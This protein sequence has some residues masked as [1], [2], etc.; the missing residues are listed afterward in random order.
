MWGGFLDEEEP[1]ASTSAAAS[2]G[3]PALGAG[4]GLTWRGDRHR[5]RDRDYPHGSAGG[6]AGGARFRANTSIL[7][8]EL[9]RVVGGRP[10]WWPR[11]AF[12]VCRLQRGASNPSRGTW[13][14]PGGAAFGG[15][16][17]DLFGV[18]LPNKG[19]LVLRAVVVSCREGTSPVE[20]GGRHGL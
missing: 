18:A 20:H 4:A 13:C 14:S 9:V 3:T 7:V 19:G 1:A 5:D 12:F 10:R 17:L 16:G 2:A 6:G 8:V 15:L 11:F